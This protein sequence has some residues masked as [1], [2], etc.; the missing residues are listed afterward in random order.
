MNEEKPKTRIRRTNEQV[1][2]AISDALTTLAGQMPLS[3]ITVN[4]LI[5]EAGIEAAV[6]FKRYSSI[7]DLI[8]EYVR[9]HDFWLGETVSY[10]KMDKEGAERYYI[11]TLEGLCRHLDS[12]GPLRDSLLWELASDSEAVKKIADGIYYL[13]LHRGKSTF[14]GLDL[15]TEKDSRRLLRLLS[16]TVHTLFAEAGKSSSDDSVRNSELARRMEAKGL[17][18]AAICDI[19]DLTPDELAALLPE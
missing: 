15:N 2:K 11:R 8:Y 9:D 10:R 1:D 17:D 12:N 3:R 18:R 7:D 19:L 16:R 5:A 14:C 4:Q 6:F 13:Y